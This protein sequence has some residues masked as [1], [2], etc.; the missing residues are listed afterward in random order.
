MRGDSGSMAREVCGEM[1]DWNSGLTDDKAAGSG[2]QE[3]RTE[4]RAN[5]KPFIGSEPEGP[6][7]SQR[8]RKLHHHG[9]RPSG[10]RRVHKEGAFWLVVHEK[11][12]VFI[13]HATGS[14]WNIL[15][16]DVDYK[17]ILVPA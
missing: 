1:T 6:S 3:L 9:R 2:G 16:G 7:Y 4:G 15:S 11:Q 12:S 10:R 5:V 17:S 13:L 8:A 14:L